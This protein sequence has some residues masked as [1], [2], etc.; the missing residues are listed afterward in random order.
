MNRI[1]GTRSK[2]NVGWSGVLIR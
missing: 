2:F 1:I